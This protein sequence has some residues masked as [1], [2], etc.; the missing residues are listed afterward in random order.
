MST[1]LISL[2]LSQI[3]FLN[4]NTKKFYRV[5][6]EINEVELFSVDELYLQ[7]LQLCLENSE[8]GSNFT[9]VIGMV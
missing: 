9:Y 1:E 5:S 2:L 3:L 4:I 8:V 6:A 7:H